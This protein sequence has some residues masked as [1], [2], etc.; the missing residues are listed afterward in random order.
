M[1]ADICFGGVQVARLVATIAAL[2]CCSSIQATAAPDHDGA[3][4][5]SMELAQANPGTAPTSTAG[6]RR[7]LLIGVGEHLY[8]KVP[9]ERKRMG[10]KKSFPEDLGGA[11]NDVEIIKDVLIRR[12]DFKPENIVTLTDSQASREAILAAMSKIVEEA[13]PEDVV[14]IHFS[15]HGSWIK[16]L[17]GDEPDNYDETLLPYDARTDE[18]AHEHIDK[19]ITAAGSHDATCINAGVSRQQ[20]TEHL[21]SIVGVDME[22]SIIGQSAEYPR[23]A[24]VGVL[25]GVHLDDIL[26]GNVHLTGQRIRRCAGAV[27]GEAGQIRTNQLLY[28]FR[29][30]HYDFPLLLS[31][32]RFSMARAW[33]S[34]PS[35]LAMIDAALPSFSISVSSV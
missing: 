1:L 25:I 27:A 18:Q 11:V 6:T 5:S 15:G 23:R 17:S 2:A 31:S 20:L 8:N 13:G 9:D 34:S 22:V 3:R 14:H 33:A 16:D 7:A 30:V 24:A 21:L 4:Q 19:L 35:A 10:K 26:H 28:S 29:R 32:R 12:F